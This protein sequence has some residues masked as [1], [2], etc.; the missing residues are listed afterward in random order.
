LTIG[1]FWNF[2]NLVRTEIGADT[3]HVIAHNMGSQVLFSLFQSGLRKI[4][5]RNNAASVRH[6]VFA[7]PDIDAENFATLAK[8]FKENAN[9]NRVTVYISKLDRALRLSSWVHGSHERVG[10]SAQPDTSYDTIDASGA[11]PAPAKD[12]YCHALLVSP[13]VITDLNWLIR[14]NDPPDK[15]S[16]TW[17]RS[18]NDL[19]YYEIGSTK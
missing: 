5:P 14:H 17:R 15:R 13:P 12:M 1:S 11:C 2:L 19:P 16:L 18:D 9:A 10:S 6:I 3:V 8:A 4:E 7:A